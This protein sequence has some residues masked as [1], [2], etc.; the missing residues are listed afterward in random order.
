MEPTCI[1]A[2]YKD[3]KCEWCDETLHSDLKARGHNYSNATC[4]EP[5]RCYT[6]GHINGSALGHNVGE[7]KCSRCGTTTFQTLTYSG[8]GPGNVTGINL[9]RGQYNIFFTHS[10]SSNFIADGNID[11]IFVNQIGKVSYV[12]QVSYETQAK[13][14]GFI[15]IEMAD[16]Y[17]TIT[18]EAIG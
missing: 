14:N 12:C 10:G 2:G 9:P 16:G 5:Q 11:G 1:T 3:L 8:R 13:S 18:I 17:W 15:N 4:F 7:A 6:C